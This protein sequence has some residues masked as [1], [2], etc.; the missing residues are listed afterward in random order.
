M[1]QPGVRKMQRGATSAFGPPP[2]LVFWVRESLGDRGGPR[3]TAGRAFK[4]T[5]AEFVEAAGG[6]GF[7]RP[8]SPAA[9]A[10]SSRRIP[11]LVCR[12]GPVATATAPTRRRQSPTHRPGIRPA[13]AL[14]MASRWA[15]TPARGNRG[16][17]GNGG[18]ES[19]P[20][21]VGDEQTGRPAKQRGQG[22]LELTRKLSGKAVQGAAAVLPWPARYRPIDSGPRQ[23]KTFQPTL[24]G[25][26]SQGFPSQGISCKGCWLPTF[27]AVPG[28][29]ELEGRG[30]GRR[31]SKRPVRMRG[32]AQSW[33]RF[34]LGDD[35]SVF[36][37]GS[38]P[39][40][41]AFRLVLTRA[42]HRKPLGL[43]PQ[44]GGRWC[45]CRI[46][47]WAGRGEGH[48]GPCWE[49]LLKGAHPASSQVFDGGADGREA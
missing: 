44:R 47:P 11:L 5:H 10:N 12:R 42:A 37:L 39:P 30:W 3:R 48:R 1:A 29:Q 20:K 16:H 26:A 43:D 14:N 13:I 24:H 28:L 22:R 41:Q 31:L 9:Q 2:P 8:V 36:C 40:S 7:G 46:E 18:S 45:R 32:W 6:N 35:C 34:G 27:P 15:S 23:G 49:G 25:L 38:A 33:L 17:R 21:K 19:D 4:K